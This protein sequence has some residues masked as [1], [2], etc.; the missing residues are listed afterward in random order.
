MDQTSQ[1]NVSSQHEADLCFALA[2]PKRIDII[3]AL[4]KHPYNVNELTMELAFPSRRL[5]P[6]EDSARTWAGPIHPTRG[7]H[8]LCLV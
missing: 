6:L 1:I 4:E 8:H 7:I 3:H 5:P 2:D